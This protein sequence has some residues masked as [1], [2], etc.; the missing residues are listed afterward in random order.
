MI[1][2]AKGSPAPAADVLLILFHFLSDAVLMCVLQGYRTCTNDFDAYLHSELIKLGILMGTITK[3]IYAPAATDFA[4]I[5]EHSKKLRAWQSSLPEPF[6]LTRSTSGNDSK[7]R[8]SVL[9]TH[10]SYLNCIVLMSR[11]VLV[12]MCATHDPYM[13]DARRGLADEY[14]QMCVSAGRQLA[15]VL[16]PNSCD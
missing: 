4:L 10:C 6:R 3:N 14:A 7:Q 12:E 9:L 1:I 8:S 11:K 5:S 13:D 2:A 16:I 15:T